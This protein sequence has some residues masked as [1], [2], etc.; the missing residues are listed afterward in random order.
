MLSGVSTSVTGYWILL[1]VLR[2]RKLSLLGYLHE[3]RP[4]SSLLLFLH[5]GVPKGNGQSVFKASQAAHSTKGRTSLGSR[6]D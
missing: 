2:S 5:H 3:L 1:P 4:L 6:S